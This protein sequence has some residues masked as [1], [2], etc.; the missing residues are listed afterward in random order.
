MHN[1][2]RKMFRR[3]AKH[4][5]EISQLVVEIC[6]YQKKSQSWRRGLLTKVVVLNEVEIRFKRVGLQDPWRDTC[7]A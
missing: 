2:N 5:R 6:V 7:R 3:A 1:S 4:A